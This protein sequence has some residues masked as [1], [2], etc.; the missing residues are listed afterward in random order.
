MKESIQT[1]GI[2]QMGC[3]YPIH[4]VDSDV[5]YGWEWGELSSA[6]LIFTDG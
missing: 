6:L 1:L 4:Q 5:M 3:S 2:E